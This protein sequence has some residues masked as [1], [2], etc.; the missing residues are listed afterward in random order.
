MFILDVPEMVPGVAVDNNTISINGNIVTLTLTWEEPFNNFDSIVNYN[1]SC[2]GDVTCPP[3]LIT[4]DN[5]TR[6]YGITNLTTMTSYTFSVVASNSFG[7]GKA[8]R[9]MIVTPSKYI[10][11][12]VT[13]IK[14]L[15]H[16][17]PLLIYH[18]LPDNSHSY[19]N[20]Q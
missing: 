12:Y 3:N 5:S 16:G 13:F 15:Y 17:Q 6:S 2:S 8:G 4:T 10:Y 1:V 9:V 11:M 18:N 20:F 7:R 14:E 19:Y